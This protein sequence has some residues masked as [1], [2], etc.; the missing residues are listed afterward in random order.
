[1]PMSDR[2]ARRVLGNLWHMSL[3]D[4]TPSR[5]ALV[6]YG[7]AAAVCAFGLVTALVAGR[8]GQAVFF[9]V[10]LVIDVS[11]ILRRWQRHRAEQ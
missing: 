2:L 11:L 1:M 8:D 3:D 9:G 6:V 10:L 7:L 5:A 4:H